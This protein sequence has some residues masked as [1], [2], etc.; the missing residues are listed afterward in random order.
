M[1]ARALGRRPRGR[2][3]TLF[4]SIILSRNLD[5]S[6]HKNAYFL[7]KTVKIRLNV[8]GSAPA[9]LISPTITA[10]LKFFSS[11]KCVLLP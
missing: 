10:L 7:E 8:R 4:A 9:L 1:V 2:I 11:A 5:R 6:M 3:G